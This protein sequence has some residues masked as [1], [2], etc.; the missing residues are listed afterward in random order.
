MME[1]R[2]F[3]TEEDQE[4]KEQRTCPVCN[5]IGDWSHVLKCEGTKISRNQILNK[6]F[7]NMHTEIT[8]RIVG[9]K[10]EDQLQKIGKCVIKYKYK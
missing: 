5:K 10:N 7:R 2:S 1:N 9:L 3:E 8:I 6:R 4:E